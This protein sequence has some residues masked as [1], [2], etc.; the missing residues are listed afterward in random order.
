MGRSSWVK[1]DA[2][3]IAINGHTMAADTTESQHPQEKRFN[4]HSISPKRISEASPVIVI[5][6]RRM[7]RRPHRSTVAH[8]SSQAP[9]PAQTESRYVQ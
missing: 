3:V 5:V 6:S 1:D 8:S 9:P 2:A 7:P 4:L